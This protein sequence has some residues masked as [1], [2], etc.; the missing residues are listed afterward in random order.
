MLGAHRECTDFVE[1]V[2][3]RRGSLRPWKTAAALET[4]RAE[5][6]AAAAAVKGADRKRGACETTNPGLFLLW[7]PSNVITHLIL[8]PDGR[9]PG[10][11]CPRA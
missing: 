1:A 10:P 11:H 3:G 5:L 4:G 9:F 7:S 8:A 2:L 6:G